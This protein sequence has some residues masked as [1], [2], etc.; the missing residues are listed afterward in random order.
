[1][2]R[3]PY[4]GWMPSSIPSI[5]GGRPIPVKIRNMGVN[6]GTV[7]DGGIRRGVLHTTETPHISLP[8]SNGCPHIA[9][10]P[11][12]TGGPVVVH[13]LIPFGK[14]G[15][16]LKNAAGGIETNRQVLC[17]IEQAG[18]TSRDLW[19]P[20][21]EQVVVTASLTQWLANELGIPEHYP[22][23]PADMA[24]GVW[25][26]TSNPWRRS[27]RFETVAGWHPHAAV[28]E[29]DHWDCGGEDIPAIL[30]MK[31]SP[32]M[33]EAVQ[34]ML[35]YREKGAKGQTHWH[36]TPLS[37]HFRDPKDLRAWMVKDKDLRRRV[38]RGLKGNVKQGDRW[39]A[40]EK[41]RLRI[42]KRQ[43]EAKGVR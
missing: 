4:S 28:D 19:L 10:G 36:S 14:M 23:D 13:H 38:W 33:V 39:V 43:V 40:V 11:E 20:S 12:R 8:W 31:P 16:A 18:Y 29:N 9:V 30:R 17:Q 25:A 21:R 22:Y 6:I 5:D 26:T 15:T 3:S 41:P 37:P 27:N 34:L 7:S 35:T 1:M 32:K 42:A 2:S 24:S